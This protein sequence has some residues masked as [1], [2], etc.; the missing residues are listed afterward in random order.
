MYAVYPECQSEPAL[1]ANGDDSIHL[2]NLSVDEQSL[3]NVKLYPNPTSGQLSIEAGEMTSVSVYD[4][5]GQCLMQMPAKDG[6]ATLDMSPLQNG[7]Y[8]IKVSTAN[9]SMMQRVVKM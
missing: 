4:L 9:G 6:Q 1:T 5:V 7:I 2:T 8:L 3:L